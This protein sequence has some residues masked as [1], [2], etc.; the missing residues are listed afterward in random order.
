MKTIHIVWEG[1]Y[2]VEEAF[3]LNGSQ[4]YGL[5]QYYGQH[6]MYG[7]DALLYLGKAQ[8]QTFS[9]RL[10]AHNWQLWTASEATIYVGRLHFEEAVPVEEWRRQIDLAERIILQSHNPSFNSSNLN[11]IGHKGEDTRVLNW[12][13]RRM[14]LPEVSVSRWEGDMSIGNLLRERFK[15]GTIN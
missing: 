5:Y 2:T 7:N 6:I 3:R 13:R 12:G 4:D 15:P 11:T 9:A 8:E 1:P 14:L 10:P